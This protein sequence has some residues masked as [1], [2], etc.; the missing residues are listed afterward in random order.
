MR[1]PQFTPPLNRRDSRSS[2][3]SSSTMTRAEM[4]ADRER[5]QRANETLEEKELRNEKKRT[6]AQIKCE[7]ESREASSERLSKQR[8]ID[9]KRRCNEND[10]QHRARLDQQRTMNMTRRSNETTEER[11]TRIRSIS[12]RRQQRVMYAKNNPSAKTWPAAISQKV[13]EQCLTE[14]NKKMSMNSLREQVCA[15]CNVRH[16]EKAM[17]TMMLSDINA[18]LL[19][20]HRDLHGTI[21]ETRMAPSQNTTSDQEAG[22]FNVQG[23]S[24]MHKMLL[25]SKHQ[26]LFPQKYE[27]RDTKNEGKCHEQT[28]H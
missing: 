7:S 21:P 5:L 3:R 10:E 4:D 22:V 15:I 23:K 11:T 8:L 19:L 17:H 1:V 9:A 13:K 28:G 6:T 18:N 25:K 14:F 16:N 20:P 24:L 26:S 2:A 27:K 12:R